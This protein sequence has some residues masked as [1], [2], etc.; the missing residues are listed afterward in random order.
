MLH[1]QQ[2]GFGG[3]VWH[4]SLVCSGLPGGPGEAGVRAGGGKKRAGT[5]GEMKRTGGET[6][7]CRE[8]A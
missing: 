5:G 6:G 2:P 7:L 8:E 3:S 4:G 1:L